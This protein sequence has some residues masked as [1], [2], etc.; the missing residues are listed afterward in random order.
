MAFNW[1][2]A[3]DAEIEYHMNPRQTI[4]NPAPLLEG[5]P[6][7]AAKARESLEGI[8]DV[9]YG[10]RPKE[11]IDVFPAQSGNLGTPPPAQIFIHGGYWR[12]MDKSDYSHLA[13]PI[14][15]AGATHISVNYDLCPEAD[16][17]IIVDEVKNAVAYCYTHADELGIDAD[18]LHLAGHSAGGHLTGMMLRQDWTSL[19]LP[20]DIL[21]SAVGVS[22]VYEPEP[23]MHTSINEDVRMDT[24]MARRNSALERA[25]TVPCPVL[26]IVGGDE[27]EGFHQ[28]TVAYGE[29]RNYNGLETEYI[30]VPGKNHFTVVDHLFQPGTAEFEKMIG[31]MRI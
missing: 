16:L 26:A 19:G 6:V 11:T 28:Q 27:P 1:R 22:G 4:E 9:R 18:R 14:V 10:D 8:Y 21:K 29:L 7:R 24:G 31:L 30:S 25:P 5:L 17:D 20:E 15:A 12:M 2:E 3:D 13:L 23:V